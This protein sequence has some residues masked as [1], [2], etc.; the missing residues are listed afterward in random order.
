M[1]GQIFPQECR[2]LI[3]ITF[4]PPLTLRLEENLFQDGSA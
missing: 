1:I 4:Y 3:L 2:V